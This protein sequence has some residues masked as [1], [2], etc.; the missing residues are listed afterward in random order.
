M[1]LFRNLFKKQETELV[2]YK[3]QLEAI[4][5]E[6]HVET[7][8]RDIVMEEIEEAERHVELEYME[9][10]LQRWANEGK[11][12]ANFEEVSFLKEIYQQY[13]E[14]VQEMSELHYEVRI[15]E[16]KNMESYLNDLGIPYTTL[17]SLELKR[18]YFALKCEFL[19][20]IS[21]ISWRE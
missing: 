14:W 13:S 3:G 16:E 5:E 6:L 11:V 9:G 7:W 21:Q 20:V 18:T 19:N 17:R 12:P 2:D 10:L 4:M 8:F 1:G 15:S